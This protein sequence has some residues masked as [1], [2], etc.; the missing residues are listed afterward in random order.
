MALVLITG[1]TGFIGSQ[2]VFDVLK[3]GYRV[4]LVVRRAEQ[5][6]K[7]ERVYS[8]FPERLEFVVVPDLTVDGCFD[9]PLQGVDYALHLASPLPGAGEDLLTPAVQGTVSILHSALKVPSIKK[10]VVTASALSIM[11]LGGA[12]DGSVI[13]ETTDIQDVDPAQVASLNPFDQ[14]Q[15]SKIASYKA[16]LDFVRD[17]HPTFDV[18][19][20]HPVF[21]FGYNQAQESADQLG[22]TCGMLYQAITAGKL[23]SDQYRGV[24]V[25]DVSAA[26]VKALDSSIKGLQ[27]YL[28]AAPPRPWSDVKTFVRQR[29]PNLPVKLE[30]Q[31]TTGYVLDTSKAERELG[32]TFKGMEDQ[33]SDVIDQQL[34]FK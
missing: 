23:F 2:V 6:T 32:L 29:Y 18:V 10:I 7:L 26:H 19:T 15:A 5:A 27:S 13:K 11:P 30:T 28:L 33:V 8:R 1:A 9:K 34:A 17:H 21:V 3:A 22:G 16:T 25:E 31:E 24:H 12:A 14:Y 4:R 20:L